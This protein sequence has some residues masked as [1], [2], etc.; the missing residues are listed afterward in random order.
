M[1]WFTH[2]RQLGIIILSL[3]IADC[4]HNY[5]RTTDFDLMDML[6]SQVAIESFSRIEPAE[7]D[8]VT[9]RLF[10]SVQ[11]PVDAAIMLSGVVAEIRSESG[12]VLTRPAQLSDRT[13]V[14][15]TSA[16]VPA[17]LIAPQNI[18]ER[19]ERLTLM[20]HWAISHNADDTEVPDSLAVS[21]RITRVYP[22]A[23]SLAGLVFVLGATALLAN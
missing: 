1:M 4:A 7:G 10:L 11:A 23:S 18:V 12:D 16:R 17:A 13:V 21:A 8:S 20:V 15:G 14:A 22:Y 9:I 19:R 2:R 3:G 6:N 5:V